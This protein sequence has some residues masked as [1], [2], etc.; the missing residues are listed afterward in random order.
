MMKSAYLEVILETKGFRLFF[1]YF[2]L[3]MMSLRADN[4]MVISYTRH[5]YFVIV[6]C[7]QLDQAQFKGAG[8]LLKR[9]TFQFST[10]IHL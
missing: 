8:R 1:F 9:A 3:F 10:T 2:R 5:S 6:R 4:P 7:S